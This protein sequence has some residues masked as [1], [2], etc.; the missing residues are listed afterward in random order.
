MGREM[1]LP[2]LMTGS[3]VALCAAAALLPYPAFAVGFVAAGKIT[4][5]ENGWFGEGIVFHHSG[6]GISGC[7]A[8]VTQFAIDK[9]HPGYKEIVAIA[10]TAHATSS[11]VELVV[12]PGVCLFGNRTKVLAIN[13]KK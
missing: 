2:S 4:S 13:M 6:P 7:G 12:D 3:L 1:K 9:N 5:I 10:M 8:S 11:N